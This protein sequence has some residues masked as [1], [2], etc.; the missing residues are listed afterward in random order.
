MNAR[1]SSA[2]QTVVR[3]PSLMGCGNRP[4]ATPCHQLL[5][6][7]GIGPLGA[8]I[9]LNRTKPYL[10]QAS[11]AVIASSTLLCTQVS[12]SRF[13]TIYFSRAFALYTVPAALYVT[14]NAGRGLSTPCQQSAFCIQRILSARL[15]L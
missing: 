1:I 15:R 3:G 6:L 10:G 11:S 9:W 12:P 5:L 4:S 7:I 14:E 13:G 8:S 2:R